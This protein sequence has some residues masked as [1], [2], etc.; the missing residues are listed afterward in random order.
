MWLPW[1]CYTSCMTMD[2]KDLLKE[3]MRLPVGARAA[4]A[5]EL[6][7]SLEG[8]EHDEEVEAAWAVEIKRRVAEIESGTATLVPWED[9]ERQ[10]L[11]TIARAK[12]G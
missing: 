11:A 9:A 7:Q 6:I 1:R 5:A 10:I 3:A 4:L 8:G 2:A 12:S